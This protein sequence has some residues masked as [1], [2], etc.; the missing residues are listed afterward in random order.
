MPA[1][2]LPRHVVATCL[3]ACLSGCVGNIGDTESRN[4]D[5]GNDIDPAV[6]IPA[7]AVLP[8][9]TQA[10]YRNSIA[11]LLGPGIPASPLEADTSP[12]LFDTIGAT[13]TTL[14]ELGTEQY[15][16]AADIATKAIFSD[17]AKRA[18][19]VG[20]EVAAA[21]DA[22]VS[23]FLKSFGRR[24]FRRPLAIDEVERWVQVATS[25][26][27][28]S[29]W[30]GLR[31]AVSGMLQSPSFLYRIE[32][33]EPNPEKPGERIILG[34][35]MAGR[36]SFLIWNT[37]PD[38]AL[39]D[40]AE[41]GEL[42]HIDGIQREAARLIDHPRGAQAMQDFF[43]QFLD[44]SRL[45][46]TSR[47]PEN[48]PAFTPSLKAAMR[49]EIELLVSDI[50]DTRGDIRS[51][52]S[53]RHTFVNSELAAHYGLDAPGTDAATFVAV[54]FDDASPRAGILTSGAFLTMNA[55][56]TQTSP[57]AR[58]KYVR[59][60]VLC[61][62]VKPPPPDVDTE[63]DPPSATNPK[64]V[65]ERLEEHQKNEACR[66]CHSFIDPPG[67]TFEHFDSIGTYRTVQ[68]GNL[69]I[70]SSGDLD[71]KP[72]NDARDLAA[73]LEE[74]QRVGA[75]MVK[76]LYRFSQ[77]RLDTEG[78]APALAGLEARFEDAGYDFRTLL[79]ELVVSDGF[80][81]LSATKEEN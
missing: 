69:P 21:G 47:T 67:F 79:I 38:D 56:E 33:G 72:V 40:A 20:C 58:G 9:L 48:Y 71:G 51:I 11:D 52:F 63:L 57:T 46:H 65:R 55:H 17:P 31:L 50:M 6:L 59:E 26:S 16:Q 75:C 64:T 80:R 53:A 2:G 43:G 25:L 34:Y 22:C 62:T 76:Q 45:E 7:E 81:S 5:D 60:R 41:R 24:A 36:L 49:R 29:A 37:I 15:E 19:L 73:L 32:L 74:D 23:G 18:A 4:V 78:E 28:E 8:R 14:S 13:S 3:V 10:Q 66:G 39:L 27:D 1:R 44:L 42:N 30:D 70:D 35:E 12:Y 77:G 61:Q 54:A 68:E